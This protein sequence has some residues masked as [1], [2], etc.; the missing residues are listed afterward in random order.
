M[1]VLTRGMGRELGEGAC[2]RK[3]GSGGGGFEAFTLLGFA[4]GFDVGPEVR[5]CG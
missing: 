3:L 1:R 2:R 5:E 4:Q